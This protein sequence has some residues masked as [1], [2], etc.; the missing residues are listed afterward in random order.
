MPNA[1]I[2]VDFLVYHKDSHFYYHNITDVM[3]WLKVNNKK[4]EIMKNV[5]LKIKKIKITNTHPTK[6]K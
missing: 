6:K 1:D 2:E 4:G 5:L 3:A